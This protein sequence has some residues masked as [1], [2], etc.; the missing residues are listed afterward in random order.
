[1]KFGAVN[2]IWVAQRISAAI[3]GAFAM[4]ALAAGV[5]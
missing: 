4:A 2:G 3:T 1:M 5:K